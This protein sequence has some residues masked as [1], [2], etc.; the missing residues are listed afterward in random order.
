[1]TQG[2]QCQ[3]RRIRLV[4]FVAH[5]PQPV[6]GGIDLGVDITRFTGAPERFQFDNQPFPLPT[7]VGQLVS[8]QVGYVVGRAQQTLCKSVSKLSET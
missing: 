6:R 8:Q 5:R 3:P 4:Q 7:Y 1:M 2:L